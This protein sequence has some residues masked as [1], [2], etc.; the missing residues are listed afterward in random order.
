MLAA[1]AARGQSGGKAKALE[2]LSQGDKRLQR[3]DK[4]D[5]RNMEKALEDWEAALSLYQAAYEAYPDP[6]IYY[7]I[8]QAEQRLGRHVDAL[9]HYQQ[10]LEEGKDLGSQLRDQVQRHII[11]VKRQLGAVVVETEVEGASVSIDGKPMARTPMSQPVFVEPGA[12]T[13]AVSRDGYTPIEEKIDLKPG[14]QLRKRVELKRMPVVVAG[15]GES[16]ASSGGGPIDQPAEVP[17]KTPLY[18]GVGVTGALFLAGTVTGFLALSKHGT[19]HDDGSPSE[20]REAARRDGKQLAGITDVLLGGALVGAAV[21]AYYYFGVY[22]PGMRAVEAEEG[23]SV[24]PPSGDDSDDGGSDEEEEEE[25]EEEEASL[26]LR[27]MP[28]V[29]DGFA[30][31]AASGWFW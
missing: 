31:V 8:A 20:D 9:L 6:Q 7:P 5:G 24:P 4:N 28:I 13:L 15:S 27:F 25:E 3:G 22:R 12:H 19:F 10:L 17:S 1:P 26:R 14:K 16:G 21:T 23:G 29:G 30:G 11:E 18:I 2:L